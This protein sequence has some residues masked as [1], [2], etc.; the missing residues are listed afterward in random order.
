MAEIIQIDF[1]ALDPIVSDFIKKEFDKCREH[2]VD[3]FMPKEKHVLN[4]GVGCAGY[5]D[6]DPR[7]L[8]V[9][10]KKPVR[11]WLPIFVH[12]TC[13]MD[14]WIENIEIWSKK[15]NDKD[16]LE[17]LDDWLQNKIELEDS[18]KKQVFDIVT[19]IEL[20]CERR[21]IEKIKKYKLPI[22]HST[23][24]RKSNAYVWSYRFMQDTRDWDHSGAYECPQV[25]KF[26]PK[27][28]DNDYSI[29]PKEIYDI[30][31]R[32]L[33]YFSGSSR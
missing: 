29:L 26:M 11:N 1:N 22:N 27:T 7:E 30:F 8:A 28:F 16:P 32:N 21:S 15:V 31:V 18:V 14:Q 10:C 9:A 19:E 2:K 17:L 5:F 13:H 3:I 23:Y 33:E 25:W 20:D 24:V 6:V 4:C 12:E